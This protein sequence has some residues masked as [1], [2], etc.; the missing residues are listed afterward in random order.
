MSRVSIKRSKNKLSVQRFP[1]CP[2]PHQSLCTLLFQPNF[3]QVGN[4]KDKVRGQERK[5][6]A[7][8]EKSWGDGQILKNQHRKVQ[9]EAELLENRLKTTNKQT[10]QKTNNQPN[11][12]PQPTKQKRTTET[13][14][15]LTGRSAIGPVGRNLCHATLL[16]VAYSGK[17]QMDKLVTWI[18]FLSCSTVYGRVN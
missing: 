6:S 18:T 1:H 10:K 16:S 3:L 13:T 7:I 9:T 11:K 12:K 17:K 8:T 14:S 15:H 2:A 5:I 4:T